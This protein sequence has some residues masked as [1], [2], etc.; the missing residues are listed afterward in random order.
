M[1][2]TTEIRKYKAGIARH[3]LIFKKY[4][5]V[6]IPLY[7]QDLENGKCVWKEILNNGVFEENS[8]FKKELIY[9]NGRF[10]C[11]NLINFYLKRQ[12]PFGLYGLLNKT[13][14]ND[15]IGSVDETIIL[16]NIIETIQDI[17]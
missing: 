1:K 9:T 12:D 4:G 16:N 2:L 8:I 7:A 13:F 5:S 6:D 14:P 10:Y 11:N 17:C 3:Q 15:R